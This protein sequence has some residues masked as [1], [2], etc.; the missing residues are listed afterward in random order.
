MAASDEYVVLDTSVLVALVC[1][2]HERHADVRRALED[3]V[4][5][6]VGLAVPGPALLEGYAVLTR[7][8]APHRLAPEDALHVLRENFRTSARTGMPTP[9]QVWSLLADAPEAGVSGGRIYDALIAR[10]AALWP[11]ATLW[12][13]DGGLA[14]FES[15]RLGVRVL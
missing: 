3:A 15:D 1:G 5:G 10:T 9:A 7:L 14:A 2:W 6:R 12:T 4:R 8:P 11:G 13:L